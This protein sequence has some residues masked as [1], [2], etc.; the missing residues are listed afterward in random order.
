MV[1][2]YFYIII[3]VHLIDVYLVGTSV[4]KTIEKIYFIIQENWYPHFIEFSY[5][6]YYLLLYSFYYPDE[7]CKML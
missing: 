7:V 6:Y 5:C 1:S 3:I 4:F 2:L